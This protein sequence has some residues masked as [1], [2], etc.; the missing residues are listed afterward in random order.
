[1][2]ELK[3]FYKKS[4]NHYSYLELHKESIALK[5]SKEQSK[6]TLIRLEAIEELLKEKIK[7]LTIEEL[8]ELSD[9]FAQEQ[10]RLNK[11]IQTLK[12]IK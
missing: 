10:E 9:Y 5:T 3:E 7:K 12:K 6:I 8:A 4:L 1:M 2:K 11:T